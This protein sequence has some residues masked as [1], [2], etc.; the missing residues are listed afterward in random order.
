MRD[1]LGDP[2]QGVHGSSHAFGGP[3]VDLPAAGQVTDPCRGEAG[4]QDVG[5][6]AFEGL[7]LIRFHGR[8]AVDVKAAVAPVRDVLGKLGAEAPLGDHHGQDLL[9]ESGAENVRVEPG[10]GLEG[11]V[12]FAPGP[13]GQQAV[14]VGMPVELVAVRLDGE[15]GRGHAVTAQGMS[16][17]LAEAS[18]SSTA[19]FPQ[20]L[21]IASE[22]GPKDFRD[23]PHQLPMRNL[24]EDLASDPL[25]KGRHS[26][27]LTRR[28][29]IASLAAE[30]Q[31][32]LLATL[33][34]ADAGEAVAEDPA[35]RK[36][37]NRLVHHRAQGAIVSFIEIAVTLLELFP[38]VLQALVKG[39]SFRMTLP[40]GHSESHHLAT[41]VE[42]KNLRTHP[43][44][45][46]PAI[47][48]T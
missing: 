16:E 32:V 30:G 19:E 15:D 26:L 35:F 41:T 8:A 47:T 14:Q 46:L 28:A 48:P 40:V 12:T 2:V 20:K 45:F 43:V 24:L 36:T 44:L 37:I 22:S 33:R 10:D 38:V 23:G 9:A 29:E 34:T 42:L 1:H 21:S 11:V 18:P 17:V 13:V 25:H 7:W 39:R 3:V 6:Q 31:Q 27:G 4:A 5:G